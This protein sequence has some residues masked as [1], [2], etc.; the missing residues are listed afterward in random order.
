MALD[1]N[2]QCSHFL[3][4]QKVHDKQ[5]IDQAKEI[6]VVSAINYETKHTMKL[7]L[8]ILSLS[9]YYTTAETATRAEMLLH[10]A[11][12][13]E[14]VQEPKHNSTSSNVPDSLA[15]CRTFLARS[16]IPGAG[17]GL[18]AGVDFATDDEVTPGDAVIPLRDVDW[19]NDYQDGDT[20]MWGALLEKRFDSF[21]TNYFIL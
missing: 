19:N 1:L 6:R 8:G 9:A 20:F 5:S 17:L 4:S 13:M 10:N 16:T 15:Q 7:L 2:A 14:P 18:F 11:R 3:A 12:T 21:L